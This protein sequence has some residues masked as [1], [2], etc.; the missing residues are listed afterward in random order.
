MLRIVIAPDKFKGSLTAPQAADAIARGVRRADQGALLTLVPMADGGE[1]T[2]DA[3]VAATAGKYL[4]AIVEDPLGRAVRARFGMLGDRKTA[5][6]AM[7]EASGLALLRPE[8]RDPFLTSTYGTGQLLLAAATEGAQRIIVG[9]GGSATNDGGIGLGHALGYRFLNKAGVAFVPRGARSLLQIDRI[10]PGEINRLIDHKTI[11]V[12]CDVDNPL[13]GPRGASAVF[14]PQKFN[15][16]KPATP[17]QIQAL[18]DGLAHLA[19]VIERDLG[20]SVANRP[21]AGAAGG[22][23]AGLIA[24]TGGRLTP[25]VDLVIEAVRL[26][27]RMAG[28]DLCITGE[29]AIDA[30]TAGGKT[31]AGV[32][33]LARS[34]QIPTIALAGTIGAGADAVLSEGVGAYFSICNQPMP[35]DRALNNAAALLEDC[36]EQAVRVFLAGRSRPDL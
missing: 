21:G 33:R 18:D 27:D 35:L 20:V 15:P 9:I 24:F 34:L 28:A 3:L 23:G 36:A 16:A 26:A 10:D 2:V 5:V 19:Q 4:S 1:G 12:A 32:A 30:S 31:V 14:G 7:A 25:G 8:E 22:L 17:A 29:G 6:I 11:D 13:V